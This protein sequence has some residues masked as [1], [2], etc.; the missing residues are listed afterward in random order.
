MIYFHRA[1]DTAT[2]E[3]ET[4]AAWL[5]ARGWE[6]CDVATHRALWAAR[7]R[8]RLEELW[9]EEGRVA[10]T[11]DDPLLPVAPGGAKVEREV[12][13]P[14]RSVKFGN[15]SLPARFFED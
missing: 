2:A 6:R 8:V 11:Q 12:G 1:L 10:Q 9:R 4:R 7:N 3:T 13:K 15:W 5:E 14:A